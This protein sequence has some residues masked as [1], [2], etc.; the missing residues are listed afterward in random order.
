[1]PHVLSIG[2]RDDC[3]AGECTHY[4]EMVRLRRNLHDGLGPG[5]AGIMMRADILARMMTDD[6][7]AAEE[8]LRDLRREA[9][10]FMTEFRR[11][12]ADR[13]PAELEDRALADGVATLAARMTGASG[14]TL[15]VEVEVADEVDELDRDV[16]VA[17]FWI[18]KEALTNVVKHAAAT[19][20]EV[21]LWADDGLR[22]S[23]VDNGI[24][25]GASDGDGC[26]IGGGTAGGAVGR[27]G[28]GTDEAVADGVVRRVRRGDAGD[29]SGGVGGG[30]ADG[31]PSG[32][33]GGGV[34]G[35]VVHVVGGVGDGVGGV[36]A[37]GVGASLVDGV[38]V[39]SRVE[40]G[41]GVGLSSMA[42]RAAEFG[43]WC[44]VSDLGF[45]V[46]VTA[47]LPEGWDCDDC[48]A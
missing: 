20:C 18:V 5:L 23:V 21:R 13:E 10:T 8:M 25:A 12:L 6:R 15:T 27:D 46:S 48:A 42:G 11:V 41:S 2:S 43:G 4:A 19:R 39:G 47:H 36:G 40:I 35:V 3:A 44:D 37:G 14:A 9:A 16:Q 38:G 32:A 34:G 26:G 24:G 28:A 29:M 17:G 1:V 31:V 7:G 22:L 30:T 45:G 33:V